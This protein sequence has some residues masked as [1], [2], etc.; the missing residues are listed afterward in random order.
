MPSAPGGDGLNTGGLTFSATNP[1]N[2][3]TYIAKID[4]EMSDHSRFFIRGIQQDDRISASPQFSGQP[5]NSEIIDTSK[6]LAAGHL[7]NIS[8]HLINNFRYRCNRQSLTLA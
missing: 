6:G 8:Q 4:Y 5:P 1:A 7:W 2:L 3:N